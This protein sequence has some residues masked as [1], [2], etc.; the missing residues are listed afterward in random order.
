MFNK[1]YLLKIVADGNEYDFKSL[2]KR[3]K[4][5]ISQNKDFS[6]FLIKLISNGELF[7]TRDRKYYLPKFEGTIVAE[8][9]I[10]AKGFGF[11]DIEDDK[12]IF[13]PINSKGTAMNGDEVEIQYFR[14]KK[15]E[16]AYQGFVK[17]VIKRNKV[18]FVGTIKKFGKNFGISPFDPSIT[19]KFRFEKSDNLKEGM[20]VKVQIINFAKDFNTIKIIKELGMHDDASVDIVAA[21]ED[22]NIPLNFQQE[23]MMETRNI[24][25]TIDGESKDGRVDHRNDMVFTIDGDD[26]KDFDDAI[27]IDKDRNGNYILYVHIADVTHYV[28]EG[29][30]IDDEAK[31]RGTSIYLAD[32]VIP[33]LPEKLSNGICSLNPN[34]DRFVITSKITIDKDGKNVST[35]IY[36]AIINSKFR[37]T[38]KE[39]N[40]FYDGDDLWGDDELTRSLKQSFELSKIIRKY[41]NDEGYIDF[42]IEEA[43]I[44]LD[45]DGKTKDI[46]PR[47]RSYSEILIEDFMVR[48]NEAVAKF[49]SDKKLSFIYRVHDKPDFE[50][51]NSLQNAINVLGMNVKIPTSP[52]PKEFSKAINK[53]KESRFDDFIK[54]MMLRTMSKAEYSPVNIGHFGLASKFYTHFTSPIRRYPDLMVH[55]ML[56]EY[57]FENKKDRSRHFGIILPDISGHS[58]SMEQRAVAL[59]RR[60]ADIKKAE[61]YEKLIGEKTTG[62]IISILKFGFFV[63]FSNK[64]GGLV[65]VSNLTDGKYELIEKGYALSNGKRKF[66]VGDKVDVIIIGASKK[67]AKI[68]LIISDMYEE[69]KKQ[70]VKINTNR[71]K[72]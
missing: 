70:Q 58:S 62:T 54:I 39:V 16:G 64:A 22:A 56:R 66:T 61:F 24:P 7:T 20:E 28:K 30:P 68:D 34:V 29:N 13:I 63:E 35:E 69:H 67:E 48:A 42:E 51:V 27:S 17:K 50:K 4:V 1:E 65:H 2:A 3:M 49:I 33:M 12:S 43:K 8:I 18:T 5:K 40:R 47:E 59:E 60:V 53:I 71:P 14:D 6:S 21:I 44:I 37:L 72:K 19:S 10:A 26:T 55:R 45:E 25:E 36:P 57:L 38:Y 23:T 11:A 32:R 41:K 15:I 46:V 9:R 52:I 31:T